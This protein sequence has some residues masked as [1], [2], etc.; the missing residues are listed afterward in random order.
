MLTGFYPE[1]NTSIFNPQT[2]F[3]KNQTRFMRKL[4]AVILLIVTLAALQTVN[5]QEQKPDTSAYPYWIEMMQNPDANFF[6]IQKA[7]NT[8]WEHRPITKGCGWKPFK[9][10]E[11]TMQWRVS[12]EGKMPSPTA[13]KEAYEKYMSGHDNSQSLAGNWVSQGPEDLPGKG[14]E[15]L[16]RISTIAFHPT[17]PD[18]IYIGAPAGGFWYT[19]TGG[20][21]WTTTTD[22]LPTLGV[23]A[24][25]IDP[26]NPS[27]IYIG[28]GDRD[29][30]DAPG[31]GVFKSTDGGQN[32]V[33]SNSGMGNAIVG[34][35][36]IDPANPQ[37]LIAGCSSGVY[38]SIDGGA[39]WQYKAGGFFKDLTFKPGNTNIIYGTYSGIFVRSTDKGETW[40]QVTNGIPSNARLV[41]GVSPAAPEVVYLLAAKSDNGFMGLYKSTDAGL[42][43]TEMSSGPNIMDWS[44]D[45]SGNGGQ[46]WYDLA[47]TVDYTNANIIYT[48][49]VNIWKSTNGGI[50]WDIN[51]HWYGGCGVP[52][53]HADQHYFKV[54]PLN[55][56]IYAGNDG[57]IYWT[58]NGGSIWHEISTG[59]VI[60]Q[61]Y[62]IGQSATVDDLVINGYQDNGT[63]LFDDGTWTAVNGGDGMECAIDQIDSQYKYATVYYGSINRIYG[64]NNQGQIAGNGVN[65][66]TEEGAWVTP[67]ILG[68]NDPNTMFIGY[69]NVWRS[70]NVKASNTSSVKW[71][72]IST[73]N[74][75]NLDVL[76]Q[77]PVNTNI[78]FASSSNA[79]FV[80]KNALEE[81]PTW[82]SITNRLPSTSAI[83][84]IETSP[85]EENTVFIVQDT[86][87]YKSTDLGLNWIEITGSLPAIHFNSITYY[88]N[89]QEGLYLGSDAGVYYKDKS[90]NDWIPFNNG[91]PASVSV[92][93]LEIYYDPNSPSGDRIKAGTYGRGLWKSD[94]YY[95][96]PTADFSANPLIIPA[97]CTVDFKDLSKGV[98]FQWSWNFTGATPS[99]STLKNPTNITYGAAGT[100][101]VQLTVT[102]NAGSNSLTKTAFITV[103]D[104]IKPLPGFYGNP[105]AY[106]NQNEIVKFVDTTKFC[107]Y[108]WNWSFSPNTYVF[109]NGTN[110][111]SQN[112]EIRFT[113][114][115]A[116]N[117]TLSVANGNGNRSITKNNYIMAGG[118]ITPFIENFE[119]NTL[120]TKGWTIENPDNEVT[121]AITDVVGSTP[122]NKAIW[123]NF[124]NYPAPAGR[125][126]RLISPALNFTGTSPVFLTFNHAYASRYTSFS[127]SLLIYVSDDCGT[128]WKRVLSLGEKGQGTFATVPKLT[129]FFAPTKVGEWCGGDWGSNC[130]TVDLTAYANK[131]NIKIAFESYNKYGNNLYLDNI[132]ISST[133]D[134]KD[135]SKSNPQLQVFPNPSSGIVTLSAPAFVEDVL[136]QIVNTQ[137]IAIYQKQIKSGAQ[138]LENVNLEKFAKGIYFV[139]LNGNTI[140]KQQKL[141]LQ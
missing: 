9:R 100:Y 125:R 47:I 98:P 56:R 53:V 52:A 97:G 102:N 117:V 132:L 68:E 127:D 120:I 84:D 135:I 109:E 21:L 138:L 130:N 59:L 86:K 114:Q 85:F 57:G 65:G 105:V 63:S 78:L 116:Y 122:G 37:V 31:Q 44:C 82:S 20:N 104:T 79:L 118:F 128:T 108:A 25:V 62:K 64:I 32:W 13:V 88:K 7:F 123:M 54:N 39:T 19:T 96:N 89:S 111:S 99:S 29:A 113:Q 4:S 11:S 137:G 92:R 71:K 17:N 35:M 12:P 90:M 15:G 23:S 43:F 16:G 58:D 42:Q 129:S 131:A 34:C 2:S 49:G 141:I 87:I 30:S 75:G 121:W 10:W 40:T 28:T 67:F 76:E 94:M 93:E 133:T 27:T 77:S 140:I 83:S 106:C 45:G 8:Y 55:N 41:I 101:P 136:I 6:E 61:A 110:A 3:K 69:K 60:S 48:G 95:S 115:G 72:K 1:K 126:D 124:F 50:D 74:T 5:A 26:M 103:S 51:A 46:A 66:I 112:P 73:I 33:Q 18:I 139:I 119:S 134:V 107:P 91:M 38:K 70:M 80:S 14:Y 81:S 24:I 22:N 36:L